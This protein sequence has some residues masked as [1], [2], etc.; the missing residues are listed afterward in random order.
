MPDAT[1]ARSWLDTN[2]DNLVAAVTFAHDIGDDVHA[3]GL[4]LAL[5]RYLEIGGHYSQALDIHHCALAAATRAGHRPAQAFAHDHIATIYGRYGRFED[6]LAEARLALH[7]HSTG[8]DGV[9]ETAPVAHTLTGIGAFSWMLRRYHEAEQYLDRA[10]E[11]ATRAED[12]RSAASAAANLAGLYD[13]QGRLTDA[14]QIGE[15][16]VE[17]FDRVGDRLGHGMSLG[18][19]GIVYLTLGRPTEALTYFERS[20][21]LFRQSNAPAF[22][23]RAVNN[24]ANV[25]RELGQYTAARDR[26]LHALAM[27]REIGDK[28]GESTVLDD[29]G[30]T[31]QQL[32]DHELA[33][34]SHR[35]A[36]NLAISTGDRSREASA[37]L[38]LGEVLAATG[39]WHEAHTHYTT[40]IAIAQAIEEPL[41]E[42]R[43]H[44]DLALAAAASGDARERQHWQHGLARDIR[45]QRT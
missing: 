7:L 22:E 38:G 25:L 6:A 12:Y 4:S 39:R 20:L 17:L 41:L 15:R 29:L 37:I 26:G 3:I 10:L 28:D 33:A 40:A 8:R 13:C 14:I 1:T 31:H 19:V 18:N 35:G 45:E 43:G 11:V 9:G 21:D 24:I 36:L 34:H 23:A 30:L 32:K 2:R 44:A 16:A 27:V 42:A 5:A